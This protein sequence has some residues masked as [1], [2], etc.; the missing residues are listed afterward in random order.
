MTYTQAYKEQLE[1]QQRENELRNQWIQT[2]LNKN[3][4]QRE[5]ISGYASAFAR[6]EI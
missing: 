5:D 1:R 2:N 3:M 6:G 4:D